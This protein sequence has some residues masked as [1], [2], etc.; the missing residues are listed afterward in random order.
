MERVLDAIFRPNIRR[1]KM[2]IKLNHVF[3][4]CLMEIDNKKKRRD[5]I[6]LTFSDF[7]EMEIG[8]VQRP[9][10]VDIVLL[11]NCSGMTAHNT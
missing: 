7:D 2:Q 8:T 6:T 9:E 10:E 11:R 3:I 5:G 1:K 4:V